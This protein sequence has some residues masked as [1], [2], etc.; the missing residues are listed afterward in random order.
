MEIERERQTKGDKHSD[1]YMDRDR[2]KDRQMAI[3]IVTDAW[4]ETERGRQ[5]DRNEP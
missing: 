5:T 3:N 1:I 4:T 2:E